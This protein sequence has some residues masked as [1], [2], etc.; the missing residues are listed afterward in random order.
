MAYDPDKVKI[1]S[2]EATGSMN[3]Y[4][5]NYKIFGKPITE[6][7][8]ASTQADAVEIVKKN[9]G[10]VGWIPTDLVVNEE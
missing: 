6:R 8:T 4:I 9:C 5:A 3:D 1:T 2:I 7:V 10:M